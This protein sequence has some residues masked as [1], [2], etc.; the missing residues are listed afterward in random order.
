MPLKGIENTISSKE[1]K[2]VNNNSPNLIKTRH[3]KLRESIQIKE[4]QV[5]NEQEN[6]VVV[7]QDDFDEL[8]PVESEKKQIERSPVKRKAQDLIDIFTDEKQLSFKSSRSSS[9]TSSIQLPHTIVDDEYDH[10]PHLKGIDLTKNEV[11]GSKVHKTSSILITKKIKA[12]RTNVN[13]K[14]VASTSIELADI[15]DSYNNNQLNVSTQTN[16]EPEIIETNV[17]TET[18]TVR[19]STRKRKASQSPPPKPAKKDESDHDD[20]ILI[21]HEINSKPILFEEDDYLTTTIKRKNLRSDSS[22]VSFSFKH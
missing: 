19:K 7:K 6:K 20:D 18:K 17:Q 13:S 8:F 11:I 14:N 16:F 5:D 9:Q 21:E 15:D 22:K 4:D 10:N 3:M 1:T 2:K 12:T